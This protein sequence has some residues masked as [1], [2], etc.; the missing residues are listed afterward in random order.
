[1]KMRQCKVCGKTLDGGEFCSSQ[2]EESHLESLRKK[3]DDAIKD[4]RGH[5]QK[6]SRA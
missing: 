4:D 2:C 3:L 1:M 6:L 5:T